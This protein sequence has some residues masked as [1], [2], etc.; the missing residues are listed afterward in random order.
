MKPEDND[1]HDEPEIESTAM[2]GVIREYARTGSSADDEQLLSEIRQSLDEV[3]KNETSSSE[4]ETPPESAWILGSSFWK[5]V[6]AIAAVL[7]LFLGI[8]S[9]VVYS[10]VAD[11][12]EIQVFTQPRF[13]PGT[14]AHVRAQ[15]RNGDS[16]DPVANAQV[17]TV[18]VSE[19]DQR[20]PF[21]TAYTDENG[22]VLVSTIFQ[23]IWRKETTHWKSGRRVKVETRPF[24]SLSPFHALSAPC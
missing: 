15:V 4:G 1:S 16:L 19:R 13:T 10:E 12:T 17:E 22:F 6:G 23:E 11:P 18:L 20:I 3:E 7:V 14:A 9:V 2:D 24:P 5:T 8:Q 21:E